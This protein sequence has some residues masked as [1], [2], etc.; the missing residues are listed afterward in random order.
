[1][2]PRCGLAP[3]SPW[4]L[5]YA[6]GGDALYDAFSVEHGRR[7]A[8]LAEYEHRKNVF[9]QNR[10]YI[11]AHNEAGRNFSMALNRFADWTQASRAFATCHH[12]PVSRQQSHRKDHRAGPSGPVH[13]WPEHVDIPVTIS[14]R[15]RV[16]LIALHC[17]ALC[18]RSS[19]R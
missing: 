11:E 12:L 15:R 18:R 5:V 9:H 8:S 19:R 6:E 10:L 2:R 14:T 4:A 7:H 16:W 1:M 13:A 17:A 3:V